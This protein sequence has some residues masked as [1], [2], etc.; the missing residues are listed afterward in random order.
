MYKPKY[1]KTKLRNPKHNNPNPKDSDQRERKSSPHQ[2]GL[3]RAWPRARVRPRSRAAWVAHGGLK[4]P[5]SLSLSLSFPL[6]SS[7]MFWW[8]F[9]DVFLVYKGYKSSFRDSV[10]MWSPCGKNAILDVMRP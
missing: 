2:C 9:F 4:P 3:G 6:G 8:F 10:S 1:L 5:T 7:L